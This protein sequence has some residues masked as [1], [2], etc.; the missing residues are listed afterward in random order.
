[1]TQFT[2]IIA[3]SQMVLKGGSQMFEMVPKGL[4]NI[5]TIKKEPVF[6]LQQVGLFHA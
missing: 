1:M 3:G 6:Q 2:E 4:K 5:Q